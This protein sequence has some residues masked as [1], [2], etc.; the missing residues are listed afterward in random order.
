[1]Q[2]ILIRHWLTLWCRT[3]TTTDAHRER[4]CVSVC[5]LWVWVSGWVGHIDTRTYTRTNTAP[6]CFTFF[7]G[8]ANKLDGAGWVH[9]AIDNGA[10]GL[11]EAG[12]TAAVVVGAGSAAAG[13]AKAIDRVGVGRADDHLVRIGATACASPRPRSGTGQRTRSYAHTDIYTQT[14]THTDIYTQTHAHTRTHAHT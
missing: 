14:H 2:P 12:N 5:A 13:G 4:V 1:M 8:V 10:E 7:S 6:L 3:Y 9:A 11:H